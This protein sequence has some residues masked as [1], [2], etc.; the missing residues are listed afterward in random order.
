MPLASAVGAGAVS[1]HRVARAAAV[2]LVAMAAPQARAEALAAAA[3]TLLVALVATGAGAR[4]VA[5]E[6]RTV[7][8]VRSLRSALAAVVAEETR[9]WPSRCRFPASQH[10]RA[11][12]PSR[13]SLHMLSPLLPP[14]G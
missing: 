7:A 3:N 13:P 2:G 4:L 8:V 5:P 6:A 9:D 10:R 1:T 14:S 12:P 11:M